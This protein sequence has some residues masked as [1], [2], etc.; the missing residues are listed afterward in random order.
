MEKKSY[1]FNQCCSVQGNSEKLLYPPDEHINF[2]CV[3]SHFKEK[4]LACMVLTP[5]KWL[6]YGRHS[7][8]AIILHKTCFS[9]IIGRPIMPNETPSPVRNRVGQDF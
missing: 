8:A 3:T 2:G 1:I 4:S 9:N 7:D 6:Q 5:G